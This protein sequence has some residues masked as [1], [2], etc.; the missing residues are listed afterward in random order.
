LFG[1]GIIGSIWARHWRA[2]AFDVRVWNRT[3]K[4][5]V[6]GFVGDAGDAARDA[7]LISLVVA[8]G[9]AVGAVLDQILDK[10]KLGTIVAQHGTI[11]ADETRL[12]ARRVLERGAHYLDMPFTGSKTGA[13][14]RQT[15]FMVGGDSA[16]FE[17][18]EKV[19]SRISKKILPVGKIGDAAAL[20]LALNLL[21]AN[22]YQGMA[23]SF[24]LAQ[25]AGIS[26]ETFFDAID[27]H[28]SKSFLTESKKPLLMAD[29][30]APQFSVKHM[31]K[32]LMLALDLAR[33][34]GLLLPQTGVLETSYTKAEEMGLADMDYASLIRTI[35]NAG[36]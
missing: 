28:A 34:L 26:K 30:F 20:K 15:V 8:D 4:P 6:P 1:L 22:F 7:D 18:V 16:V 5:G 27:F 9:Q 35:Q 13:E 29:D 14:N 24:R 31:H 11:G 32:D 19:Y 21:L 36:D 23:E 3:P 17:K 10:I 12:F 33:S 25:Q 2:D